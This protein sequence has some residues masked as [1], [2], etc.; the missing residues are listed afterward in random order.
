[1]TTIA[2]GGKNFYG[3]AVGILMLETKFPRVHGDIG[4]AA[5]WPFPVM[6]HCVKGA[7]LDRVV[8][9][10]A[11]GLLDRF[12]AAGQELVNLGADGITTSCG[13]MSLF[14]QELADRLPVPV[15]SSSLLQVSMINRLLG[16][17]RRTGIITV[18]K[19]SLS[20]D[21]LNAVGVPPDTPVMG[22]ENGMEFTRAVLGDEDRL[23]T[24]LATRDL[25]RAAQDLKEG[26]PGVGA[27][28]LECTNMGPYAAAVR[29]AVNLPVYSIY[30][31]IQWFQA[32][33]LPRGF[34]RQVMDP[35]AV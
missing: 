1:M 11:D 26:H 14:Q 34:D 5:T 9:Q 12:V 20:R 7:S 2:L 27:I 18:K 30:S 10:R 13:F 6:M 23:D 17:G 33:L 8:N 22:T 21:H 24:E 28:V 32:G 4:N 3:A 16:Q 29:Q 15:A 25:V 35:R 19:Q 31:F